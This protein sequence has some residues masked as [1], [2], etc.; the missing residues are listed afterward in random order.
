MLEQTAA[1]GKCIAVVDIGSTSI[2]LLVATTAGRFGVRM[3]YS[4]TLEVRIGSGL[5]QEHFELPPSAIQRAT[6]AIKTLVDVAKTYHPETIELIATSAVRDAVNRDVFCKAVSK[7]CGVNVRILSGMEEAAYIVKGV[8]LDPQ[9]R[10]I[11]HF[12]VL[13]IGGGSAECIE[14]YRR[15]VLQKVSLPLGS[16]RLKEKFIDN[17]QAAISEATL[18]TIAEHVAQVFRQSKFYF[19][20]GVPIIGT[21]CI[22][23]PRKLLIVDGK[24]PRGAAQIPVHMLEELML[25]MSQRPTAER[26]IGNPLP[27]ER[28][29][30]FP[31]VL[32]AEVAIAK[33][34][35][36]DHYLASI[37]NL[38]F[39]YADHM[40][41]QRPKGYPHVM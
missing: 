4:Q 9:I 12:Y 6:D 36:I 27:A 7:T 31:I 34:A 20:A 25:S 5:C 10:A 32:A 41:H 19:L 38:R 29:D 18:R 14:C 28:A 35:K 37:R 39:G 1:C 40:L 11:E 8:L 15:R 33:L 17:D 21:G 30:V 3:L 13:D 2:K 23:L 24:L 22:G 16:V 26:S